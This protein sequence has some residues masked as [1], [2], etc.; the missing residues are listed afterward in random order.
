MISTRWIMF[1]VQDITKFSTGKKLSNYAED[2]I[3]S[4]LSLSN[5]IDISV[6]FQDRM[7]PAKQIARKLAQQGYKISADQKNLIGNIVNGHIT[8]IDSYEFD[9][10]D[11]FNWHAGDFGDSGS[12]FWGAHSGAR[13][14]MQDNDF[15]A[16]RFYNKFGGGF[17]RAWVCIVNDDSAIVFN[18][19]GLETKQIAQILGQYT[20][21]PIKEVRLENEGQ[22]NGTL[23]INSN[24]YAI[25][26]F[27]HSSYDFDI[28][29]EGSYSCEYCGDRINEDNMRHTDYA[30]LC[31][32]CYDDNYFYCE[33]CET[34]H[35]TD[36]TEAVEIQIY[37]KYSKSFYSAT[38]CPEKAQEHGYYQCESCE[39]WSEETR[40]T[41]DD[42]YNYCPDCAK[43]NNYHECESC[44]DFLECD[45]TIKAQ[46]S[47]DDTHYC[48][49]CQDDVC[50]HCGDESDDKIGDLCK[51]CA[52]SVSYCPICKDYTE[53]QKF[54]FEG[55]TFCS[56][57][58]NE[59][60]TRLELGHECQ[61]ST[62]EELTV[63]S[64]GQCHMHRNNEAQLTLLNEAM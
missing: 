8:D 57:H 3:K 53:L 6:N 29:D 27:P 38:V 15:L 14:M 41:D 10:T 46:V 24:G 58:E 50:F 7:K 43:E 55:Y 51:D 56:K 11:H 63:H 64:S 36:D 25:G 1:Q 20:D 34:D 26:D 52:E 21:K 2:R 4:E 9:F 49:D 12:C 32:S 17:A 13:E 16:V 59:V 47:T 22:D 37:S 33:Q 60:L 42:K 40:N 54:V 19:Y 5:G 31:E 62:C 30:I 18:G 45:L 48:N 23:W 39:G 44:G 61:D 28:D 35:S